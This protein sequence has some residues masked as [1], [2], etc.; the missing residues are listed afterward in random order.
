MLYYMPMVQPLIAIGSGLLEAILFTHGNYRQTGQSYGTEI[1]PVEALSWSWSGA[2]RGLLPGTAVGLV[3]GG[4]GW[5]LFGR[6][7]ALASGLCLALML[8][9]QAGLQHM[10]IE[11]KSVPN[12]GIHLSVRNGLLVAVLMGASAG[13]LTGLIWGADFGLLLGLI[14]TFGGGMVNGGQRVIRHGLIRLLL[15]RNGRIPLQLAIFLDTAAD[16]ALLYKVGGGYVFMHQLLQ[17]QFIR[18]H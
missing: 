18:L 17:K 2:V 13:L 6:S 1:A 12:Q 8:V 4:L 9:V 16:H 7:F 15:W 11:T 5:W 10:A 14:F 3:I